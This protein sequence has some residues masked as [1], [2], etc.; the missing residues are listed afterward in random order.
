MRCSPVSAT[1]L[2][3][4][5][6]R[7]NPSVLASFAGASESLCLKITPPA[8]MARSSEKQAAA[9]EIARHRPSPVAPPR[10]AHTRRATQRPGGSPPANTLRTSGCSRA[11][12]RPPPRR[13]RSCWPAIEGLRHALH[14]LRHREVA[15]THLAQ[16]VVH[17]APERIEQGRVLVPRLAAARRS[18]RTTMARCSTI[19]SKRPSTVSAPRILHKIPAIAPVPRWRHRACRWSRGGTA[20][21]SVKIMGSGSRGASRSGAGCVSGRRGVGHRAWGARG[22]PG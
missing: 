1:F 2:Q 17:V 18:R 5:P 3:R 8:K 21:I 4:G 9:A 16:I 10:G 20:G 12:G 22:M 15:D 11:T 7:A 13:F 19:M 14:L 6:G